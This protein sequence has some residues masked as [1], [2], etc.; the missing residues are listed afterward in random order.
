MISSINRD[1]LKNDQIAVIKWQLN[2]EMLIKEN[3]QAKYIHL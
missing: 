2:N 3:I 1:K